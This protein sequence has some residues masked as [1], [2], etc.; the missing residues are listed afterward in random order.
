MIYKTST[1]GDTI[2]NVYEHSHDS[3]TLNFFGLLRKFNISDDLYTRL[4]FPEM[5]VFKD[6]ACLKVIFD[7]QGQLLTRS[8]GNTLPVDKSYRHLSGISIQRKKKTRQ[9]YC[10]TNLINHILSQCLNCYK[11]KNNVVID[12]EM[13]ANL[14]GYWQKTSPRKLKTIQRKAKHRWTLVV[15]LVVYHQIPS[16]N[17]I[18]LWLNLW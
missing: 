1:N 7:N 17:R 12:S 8:T 16:L 18:L 4:K 10:C 5:I 6:N 9:A 3:E 2:R 13:Q 11:C 15:S 14:K